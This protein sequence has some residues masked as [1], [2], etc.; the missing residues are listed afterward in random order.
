M[1]P[2]VSIGMPVYNS[3]RYLEETLDSILAQTFADFELIIS[4][5]GSTDRTDEICRRYAEADSRIRYDRNPKNM[6]ASY[7]Y[8]KVFRLARGVYFKHAAYDDLLAPT[9]LER[10]VEVL[11]REPAVVLA[12]P[13]CQ[14]IDDAGQP[15]HTAPPLMELRSREKT[16]HERFRRYIPR[17]SSQTMCDPI[18]GLYRTETFGRTRLIQSYPAQDAI[19]LGEITLLGEIEEVPEVLFFERWHKGGSIMSNQKIDDLYAWYDPDMRGRL[20]NILVHW[21]WV[22]ELARAIGRAPISRSEKL[23]CY[24]TLRL[25]ALRNAGGMV[26]DL[27]W[28]SRYLARVALGSIIRRVSGPPRPSSSEV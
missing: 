10:L 4:D 26:S 25:Y 1:E 12:Y 2:K 8:N 15:N 18:F 3:E 11:D 19:L 24:F 22:I 16:A 20:P 27:Y 7:N 21:R 5:N 14:I 28:A 9:Y 17:S 23:K 6:G 13:R